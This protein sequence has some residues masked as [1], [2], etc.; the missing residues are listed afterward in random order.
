VAQ[1]LPKSIASPALVAYMLVAKFCHAL[2]FYRQEQAFGRLGI[3]ISR[4]DMANW[5]M[6]RATDGFSRCF[7]RHNSMR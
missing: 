3:Q 5:S 4:Q 1:L 2:P 7:T 6:A